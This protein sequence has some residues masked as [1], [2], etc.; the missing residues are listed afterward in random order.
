MVIVVVV[1]VL[2]VDIFMTDTVVGVDTYNVGTENYRKRTCD[3]A[4]HITNVNRHA[5]GDQPKRLWGWQ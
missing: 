5:N 4:F 1:V 2:V 3:C